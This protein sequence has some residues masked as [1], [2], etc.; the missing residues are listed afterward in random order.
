MARTSGIGRS[1]LSLRGGKGKSI[2]A[3][4]RTASR[5]SSAEANKEA[6]GE[7]TADLP[8]APSPLSITGSGTSW[9]SSE[10]AG[11]P[12]AA[13]RGGPADGVLCRGLGSGSPG[14]GGST[15]AGMARVIGKKG[16][17]EKSAGAVMSASRLTEASDLITIGLGSD[18]RIGS[19]ARSG[20]GTAA[21]S[22]PLANESVPSTAP[23]SAR[24]LVGGPTLIATGETRICRICWP[25]AASRESE[26]RAQKI[27]GIVLPYRTSPAWATTERAKH[28]RRALR[29]PQLSQ[30]INPRTRVPSPSNA[31]AP[32]S[33]R[34][35]SK[36]DS[37][38][39]PLS[40]PVIAL[41]SVRAGNPPHEREA[42]L[43]TCIGL[44]I[45]RGRDWKPI[46]A[47]CPI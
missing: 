46:L 2:L 40:S 42:T 41:A 12:T 6:A 7:E 8:L 29:E 15:P 16:C 44:T 11:A 33:A 39:S 20:E 21:V 34:I 30:A 26:L 17:V 23:D 22:L 5:R 13:S 24:L 10:A 25:L 4:S 28:F 3:C 14:L 36:K 31:Q 1:E 19:V 35:K 32:R 37:R 18:S 47:I 27:E 43:F 9:A 45:P 38:S